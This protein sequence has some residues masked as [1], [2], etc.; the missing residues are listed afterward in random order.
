MLSEFD[1]IVTSTDFDDFV[2]EFTRSFLREFYG[3]TDYFCIVSIAKDS[4]FDIIERA[5]LFFR[6]IDETP[7]L[8]YSILNYGTDRFDDQSD[9]SEF[10]EEDW[11]DLICTY[12]DLFVVDL[13]SVT[14]VPIKYACKLNK[15]VYPNWDLIGRKTTNFNQKFNLKILKYLYGAMVEDSSCEKS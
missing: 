7:R 2:L 4:T 12:L 8:V 9:T 11:F 14:K 13:F 1:K 15:G 6:Q 5:K 10:D 3:T